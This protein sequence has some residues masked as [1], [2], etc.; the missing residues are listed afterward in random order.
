MTLWRTLERAPA[1]A[2]ELALA[3]LERQ[4]EARAAGELGAPG[5]GGEHDGVGAQHALGGA[6][7]L[8]GQDLLDRVS[9]VDPRAGGAR[10]DRHRAGDR[11]RVAL[12]VVGE[13]RG[14]EEVRREPGL[15]RARLL[16]LE[17]LAAHAGGAQ[18]LE[19]RRLGGQARL[20]AMDDERAL[21]A[22]P[23]QLAVA[24]LDVV[25]GG[26]AEDRERELGAGVLVRAQHVAL[27]EAGRAARHLAGVE[28]VDLDAAHRQRV[29]RRRADDPGADDA[30]FMG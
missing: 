13:Q 15:E 22:D 30:T 28:Q 25:E 1:E 10:L 24:A 7:A 18:A 19:P 3:R 14:A 2:D 6:H 17:Q 4:L 21:A 12:E 9:G 26:A 5:A 27:A 20:V 16:G 11:A 8:A 23:R 29:G